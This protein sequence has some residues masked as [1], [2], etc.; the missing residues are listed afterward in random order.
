[1]SEAI[2]TAV[3]APEIKK[4]NQGLQVQKDNFYQPLSSPVEQILFLQRTVGNH[5]VQRI[6]KSGAMQAK[7][8]IGAPGDVYEQ[9]A[10][11]V[12]D[13]VMR[14]PEPNAVSGKTSDNPVQPACPKCS[15]RRL[16]EEQDI[17]QLEEV[18]GSTL[19]IKQGMETDINAIRSGGQPLPESARVFFEPRFGLD[20]SGVRVHTD[21]KAADAA[22]AVNARAFTVGR[23]VVFGKGEYAP[24][25]ETGKT[26]MAH[27]LTH[28]VQQRSAPLL[29]NI[30]RFSYGEHQSVGDI[31]SGGKYVIL[32]EGRGGLPEYKISYG[33]MVA[34]AGDY[35]GSLDEMKRLASTASGQRKLDYA[36]S[37]GGAVNEPIGITEE[38]K[39]EI[40]DLYFRLNLSNFHH[41]SRTTTHDNNLNYYLK[42]HEKAL[43]EAFMAKMRGKS[44]D[45]AVL[46]ESFHTHFL[47]DAFTGG[48]ITSP[49]QE[50]S[51][52]WGKIYPLFVENFFN[53]LAE[54]MATHIND[55]TI[56]AGT[57]KT[58]AGLKSIIISEVKS[59][60]PAGV[61]GYSLGGLISIAI[62]D[63]YNKTGLDVVSEVDAN[64]KQVEGGYKW[65][66]F[67]EITKLDERVAQDQKQMVV[68]AVRA[69]LE[70]IS[71]AH[72]CE[73][74]ECFK[75]IGSNSKVAKFVPKID[76]TSKRNID[77]KWKFTTVD[78]VINNNDLMTAISETIGPNG[79]IGKLLSGAAK[80]LSTSKQGTNPQA[81]FED[82][83]SRLR[84][85]T[86][87][88]LKEIANYVPG[89]VGHHF[90]TDTMSRDYIED[91]MK[92]GR[93]EELTTVQM[94]GFINKMLK[95]AT[96][97]A[98]EQAILKVLR[99]ANKKGNVYEVVNNVGGFW[100]LEKDFQGEEWHLLLNVLTEKYFRILPNKTDF[101]RWLVNNTYREWGEEACITVLNAANK[102]EFTD[103]VKNITK[104]KLDSFLDGAEQKRFDEL[105]II[106]NYI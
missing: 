19:E 26:L 99:A 79:E 6:M 92:N 46:I 87:L 47:T 98:D 29:D 69:G 106:H 36:R 74:I 2:R 89:G 78:G 42:G 11:R 62:H 44:I 60:A 38:E 65:K 91:L 52:Y 77:F 67:G 51:E 20:F 75:G 94:V 50:A 28:A 96:G 49:R 82:W 72:E 73:N 93:L 27:E 63:W 68:S 64:G 103:I 3:K 55:N 84:N 17:L 100:R 85:N 40:D 76:P 57:F 105:L 9:E 102:S 88:V 25:T 7:L 37:K 90:S 41:F 16:P 21:A 58:I 8:R 70:E 18:P 56:I 22:R 97:N 5:A 53:H 13:A 15:D 95:G 14:M 39:K 12:A 83:L 31:G 61:N 4:E 10:D 33:E 34:L 66:A 80:K 1:M 59:L 43:N 101:V 30:Q 24:M 54:H 45:E 23:D 104:K 86:G 71:V 32:F 48:H 81:A 35:F